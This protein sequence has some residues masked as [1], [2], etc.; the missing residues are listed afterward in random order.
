MRLGNKTAIASYKKLVKTGRISW[1]IKD[2][3]D[4]TFIKQYH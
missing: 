2:W 1:H 4:R 3:I